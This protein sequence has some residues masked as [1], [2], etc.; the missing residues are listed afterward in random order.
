[1]GAK[2]ETAIL[3]AT[4]INS[5]PMIELLLAQGADP[6][7][8]R[9]RPLCWAAQQGNKAVAELLLKA[10]SEVNGTGDDG[11]T[12][13]HQAV[14]RGYKSMADLL[15]QYGADLNARNEKVVSAETLV[16]FGENF[17]GPSLSSLA[18][19]HCAIFR[20]N[21]AMLQ[22]LCS[23]KADLNIKEGRGNTPLYLA[24]NKGSKEA[25]QILLAA[26]ADASILNQDGQSVPM[27]AVER[28]QAAIVDLLLSK[29]LDPNQKYGIGHGVQEY[30][31]CH[32]ASGRKLQAMEV[33]LKH[34]A[35]ISIDDN[36][37]LFLGIQNGGSPVVAKLLAEG[38]PVNGGR[39]FNDRRFSPLHFAILNAAE[40]SAKSLLAA[41]VDVDLALENGA[42]PLHLAV[43]M[44]S[45]DMVAALLAAGAN[46]NRVDKSGDTPLS[47]ALTARDGFAVMHVPRPQLEDPQVR[48]G[49]FPS[50]FPPPGTP[51]AP[52]MPGAP[53]IG[54]RPFGNP[55]MDS[56]DEV[57]SRLNAE[58]LAQIN[59]QRNTE[60]NGQ[61]PDGVL[62]TAVS[63]LA[64]R[65]VRD[66]YLRGQV[67][68]KYD[69]IIQ[70]LVKHGARE[71]ADRAYHIFVKY[72][73]NPAERVFT[74][75]AAQANHFTLLELAYF[76]ARLHYV[77]Y[78]DWSRL[79]IHRFAT[80]Q[81]PAKVEFDLLARLSASEVKDEHLA[82]GDVVEIPEMIH[83]VA[84]AAS[85]F[86]AEALSA[87]L[88]RLARKV[89]VNVGQKE[90]SLDLGWV[91]ARRSEPNGSPYSTV[92][93]IAGRYYQ[94]T[95]NLRV[96]RPVAAN[97]PG[98]A[99]SRPAG[100]RSRKAADNRS[101]W[102]RTLIQNA[103]VV[104]NTSDL[105]RV[106]VLHA[107]APDGERK[108]LVYNL[109]DVKFP[110]D[111]WLEDGDVVT[112]PDKE[113]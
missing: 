81:G 85:E 73:T 43:L 95:D 60:L 25:V 89:T 18:P 8:G 14:I 112:V 105:T 33:L 83:Q 23:H 58:I 91:P 102:L 40:S 86:P 78:P 74:R 94:E 106:K 57:A 87:L 6:N 113:K 11:L 21:L 26:G 34:H 32:A 107:S 49:L 76:A 90:N 54:P 12:A 52:G 44:Q 67:N 64:T 69:E 59:T 63:T 101:C 28:D 103:N 10:K 77:V 3:L 100:V 104:L 5:I 50:V 72:G 46:P 79:T 75:D 93:T 38:A 82:W 15:L 7:V 27:L 111:L 48:A 16:P 2:G 109:T 42:T 61:R 37:A 39:K 99:P 13:L 70:L 29:G 9:T 96:P 84:E 41:K 45:P 65:S 66:L 4:E 30:P 17:T 88:D 110:D 62:S 1:M 80:N 53:P 68:S 22:W 47:V 56:S 51:V 20:E 55:A 98:R 31:L 108:E 36:K 92:A 35:N 19:V 71:D 24:A 97:L